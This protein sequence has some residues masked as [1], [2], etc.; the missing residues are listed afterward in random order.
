MKNNSNLLVRVFAVVVFTILMQAKSYAQSVPN[1]L[2]IVPDK[3]TYSDFLMSPWKDGAPTLVAF[4]DPLCGYCIKALK[5]RARLENYNVFLFWSP[6]LSEG[7]KIKV[8]TFFTCEKPVT[9][10]ILDAVM[11]RKN[12]SC[13]GPENTKLRRLNDQ[14]M[15][16]Y[17]P[18]FVP[19]YWFGGQRQTFA[20]LKLSKSSLDLIKQIEA[21]SSVKIPWQRYTDLA[22]NSKMPKDKPNIALVLPAK[23]QLSA[24]TIDSLKKDNRLNWFLLSADTQSNKR[25]IEFRML[26]NIHDVVRPLY[27]LEGKQLSAD[28]QKRVITGKLKGLLASYSS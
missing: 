20:Q 6:I 19:Q 1:P 18:N 16:R 2:L 5:Q 17:Q 22:L 7:S 11:L 15:A 9:D 4:K 26:N 28:E 12:V 24:E 8:N 27:I 23:M 10:E 13:N 25:D 3:E 14:M 21:L